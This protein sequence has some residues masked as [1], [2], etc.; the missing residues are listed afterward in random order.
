MASDKKNRV[1]ITGGGTYLGINLASALIAEGAEVTLILRE[2]NVKRLGALESRVRWFT[3]DVW[4]AASLKGRARGHGTVIH[5]VGS[6]VADPAAGFTFQRLNVVSTRNVAGMCVSDG[7]PHFILLSAVGA[8][9]VNNQYV[10]A[11]REAE[12]AVKRM[13]IT[14]SVIRAPITYVRGTKRPLLFQMISILGRIPPISWVLGNIIPMPLDI[15]ARGVSRIA[16]NPPDSHQIFYAGDLRRLNQRH[17]IRGDVP[18][19][20]AFSAPD[21]KT[22]PFELLDED[23]P[24]GWNPRDKN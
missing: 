16:L 21:D 8:P 17:E 7:V 10:Q 5:T 15:L 4:D 22:L 2:D 24:F 12:N 18:A 6:M 1:L 13:G 3:A 9:W 14:V 23:T 11:K 20:T 19:M